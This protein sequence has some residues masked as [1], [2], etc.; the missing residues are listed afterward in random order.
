MSLT[1][2]S[3]YSIYDSINKSLIFHDDFNISLELL[4]N[5]IT[6]LTFDKSFNHLVNN[7]TNSIT[8]LTFGKSF[9]YLVDNLPNSI[10]HLTFGKSFNHLVENPPIFVEKIIIF[11]YQ[12]KLLK[13][14]PYGCK[15][16]IIK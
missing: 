6:H 5:N 10:T 3:K 12:K 4:P 2:Y 16:K 15:I 13:K 1:K 7:L 14:F 8:H 11:D 9:N